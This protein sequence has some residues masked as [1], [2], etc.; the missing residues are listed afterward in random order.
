MLA[1]P[2]LYRFGILICCPW[3]LSRDHLFTQMTIS[4][5]VQKLYSVV[6]PQ[7]WPGSLMSSR[8]PSLQ[9]LGPAVR[10]WWQSRGCQGLWGRSC[11][12]CSWLYVRLV[13]HYLVVQIWDFKNSLPRI[14]ESVIEWTFI[15][16]IIWGEIIFESLSTCIRFNPNNSVDNLDSWSQLSFCGQV[17]NQQAVRGARELDMRTAKG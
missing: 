13:N 12:C 3:T 5:A 8:V 4:F 11:V 2:A 9:D 15:L 14:S 16:K 7:G 10:R 6:W 17:E 1:F